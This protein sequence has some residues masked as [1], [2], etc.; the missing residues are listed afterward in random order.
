MK[1]KNNIQK[2]DINLTKNI[3]NPCVFYHKH[4]ITDT[5]I[6]TNLAVY[7]YIYVNLRSSQ[8]KEHPELKTIYKKTLRIAH[9]LAEVNHIQLTLTFKKIAKIHI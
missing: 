3:H 2:L 5:N 7:I 9:E 4:F 8:E 1:Q 6:D